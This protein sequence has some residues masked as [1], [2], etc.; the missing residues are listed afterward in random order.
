MFLRW[1]ILVCLVVVVRSE[2]ED[3][4]CTQGPP[5]QCRPS[6]D[7]SD[8]KGTFPGEEFLDNHCSSVLTLLQCV[9]DFHGSCP[10]SQFSS[11][12]L[13]LR[14][15]LEV[16]NILCDDSSEITA[17]YRE[18][19]DCYNN[20]TYESAMCGMVGYGEVENFIKEMKDTDDFPENTEPLQTCIYIQAILKCVVETA[21]AICGN[22]ETSPLRQLAQR[23][24]DEFQ[25][26]ACPGDLSQW[27]DKFESYLEEEYERRRNAINLIYE[28]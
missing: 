5:T 2:D 13:Y 16:A 4:D 28:N 3:E 24:V 19:V 22:E 18:N 7:P 15:L 17:G 25:K 12:A 11:E 10:D 26:D 8:L 9:I 27:K 23:F 1:A 20:H 21:S 6:W 14:P